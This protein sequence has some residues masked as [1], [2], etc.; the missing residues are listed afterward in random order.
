MPEGVGGTA[1]RVLRADPVSAWVETVPEHVI[2]PTLQRVRAHDAVTAAALST[3]VTPLPVR[4]GQTFESDDA[5]R[6]ALGAQAS[7][8]MADLERVRGLVEMR[9]V[10]ALAVSQ[11][12]DAIAG[13]ATPGRAYMQ[14][15][16][17]NRGM[18]QIVQAGAAAVREQL[19]AMVRPF[20]R[21]EALVVAAS[22]SPILTL[23]HLVA[24]GDVAGYRAALDTFE[25]GMGV[26]RLV[27]CGPLAPWQFVSPPA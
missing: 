26:K 6:E 19:S 2:P 5:C 9:V 23:S 20:V 1:V 27:T 24:R 11:A 17:R 25:P 3:G 4:F 12:P 21:D 15:L 22:P 13:T 18:E 8:L 7:R 14:A 16:M 10:V